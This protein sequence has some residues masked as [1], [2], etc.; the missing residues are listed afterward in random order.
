MTNPLVWFLIA[1]ILF[2][3]P[4]AAYKTISCRVC[5][6]NPVESHGLCR[7]CRA[8]KRLMEP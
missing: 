1:L 4:I 3:V 8:I 7:S 2:L 6:N 5:G